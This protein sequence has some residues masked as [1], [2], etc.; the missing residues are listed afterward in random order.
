MYIVCH[1]TFHSPVL[2]ILTF[3]VYTLRIQWVLQPVLRDPVFGCS[4]W[5]R[6]WNN[7]HYLSLQ[8]NQRSP[9]AAHFSVVLHSPFRLSFYKEW[10]QHGGTKNSGRQER[11]R[12]SVKKETSDRT[13]LSPPSFFHFILFCP[14][15]SS[16]RS[17]C[18][19]LIH[20]SQPP[21]RFF[22]F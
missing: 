9:C 17:P 8:C 15:E 10:A 4:I 1:L 21:C 6:V 5:F 3:F 7:S 19:A 2:L 16:S 12:T 14:N 11:A 22:V 13:L 18:S 20:P